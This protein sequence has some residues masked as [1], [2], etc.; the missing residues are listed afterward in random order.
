MSSNRLLAL[1][2]AIGQLRSLSVLVVWA[3]RLSTLPAEVAQLSQLLE[4]SASQ[5]HLVDLPPCFGRLHEDLSLNLID[6][7]LQKPPL[8]VASRGVVAIRRYFDALSRRE[9]AVSR[10]AKLVLVGDGEVGKTSLLR[11]LQWRRAAPTGADERTIQLDMS[12]LG[13]T[14]APP[15]QGSSAACSPGKPTEAT[16]R[17]DDHGVPRFGAQTEA[18]SI[19]PEEEEAR[20]RLGE[21]EASAVLFSCWDLSGQAEYAPAQQPFIRCGP[22]FLLAIPAHRCHDDEYPALLGRWLDVLQAGA[23]GAIVQPVLTQA[24]RLLSEAELAAAVDR[25]VLR[26]VTHCTAGLPSAIATEGKV[27]YEVL[28]ENIGCASRAR[29]PYSSTPQPMYPVGSTPRLSPILPPSP[30]LP[31]PVHSSSCCIGWATSEF[32]A[33]DAVQTDLGRQG[34]SWCLNVTNGKLRHRRVESYAKTQT[35]PGDRTAERCT[36]GPY[37][38]GDVIGM[39]IDFH[40]GELWMARNDEWFIAFKVDPAELA[41]SGGL[42]PAF[43]G[44]GVLLSVNYGARPFVHGPPDARFYRA[45]APSAPVG[46]CEQLRGQPSAFV[47]TALWKPAMLRERAAGAI[48]WVQRRVSEH[49]EHYRR[50]CAS[51]ASFQAAPPAPLRVQRIIPVCSGV[52][53]G[54]PTGDDVRER[55]EDIACASPPLLPSL[56]FCIPSS[57]VPVFTWLRALR[58]GLPAAEALRRSLAGEPPMD[59]RVDASVEQ[60][61]PYARISALR[62]LWE[63]TAQPMD[64]SEQAIFTDGQIIE[65][66]LDLFSAMGEVSSPRCECRLPPDCLRVASGLLLSALMASGCL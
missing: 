50:R 63:E 44:V 14:K 43:E 27:F 60:R 22:L 64:A 26:T 39:A 32:I 12:M 17:E 30:P 35:A 57:W 40:R 23:P 56:G 8:A 33:A 51:A 21:R 54:E 37:S 55:L 52:P 65:D 59:P 62:E 41:E 10:S 3:N 34:D 13:V 24:D 61:R 2:R 28:V 49:R 20:A 11:L 29:P 25:H 36:K 19:T 48:E 4:L 7:P 18:A 45:L 31:S 9:A 58:D 1:P 16:I 15:M 6:N 47:L 5:N 42:F 38:D 46:Y 53:G 66:A